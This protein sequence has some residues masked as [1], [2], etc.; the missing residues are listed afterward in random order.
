MSFTRN[1]HSSR[2]GERG[3]ALVG[4]L[5][6]LLMMSAL[7]SALAV[8]GHT[9]TLVTRNH[10]TAAQARAAAEAGLN[11][12]SEIV[13]AWIL[14]WKQNGYVDA[15]AALDGLLAGVDGNT[16]F[17]SAYGYDL[18]FGD[19]NKGFFVAVIALD[20]PSIDIGLQ[21]RL[22]RQSGVGANEESGIAIEQLGTLAKAITDGFD[23]DEAKRPVTTGFAPEEVVDDFDLESAQFTRSKTLNRNKGN[24]FVAQGL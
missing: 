14:K 17:L 7:A 9:E 1:F 13:I 12:A 22:D 23:D 5:L 10:Q 15:A 21:K 11:H 19:T 18:T 8:S 4:V 2:S 6:L 20:L 3:T 24:G 16:N